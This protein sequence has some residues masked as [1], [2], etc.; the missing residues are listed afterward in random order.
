MVGGEISSL[1]MWDGKVPP[2][3][4]EPGSSGLKGRRVNRLR[5]G[6]AYIMPGH[7]TAAAG[8]QPG[9]A[10]ATALGQTP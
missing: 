7:A 4:L 10:A 2:P 3:G 1:R 8:G 6:G 5:Y 9:L